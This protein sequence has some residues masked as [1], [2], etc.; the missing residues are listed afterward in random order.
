[1]IG[2][3]FLGFTGINEAVHTKNKCKKIRFLGI[4]LVML[5]AIGTMLALYIFQ[6]NQLLPVLKEVG[7][8]TELLTM[9]IIGTFLFGLMGAWL[10][11]TNI[12]FL[13]SDLPLWLSLPI[14]RKKLVTGKT[15]IAYAFEL[16]PAL[17]F[18]LPPLI[19]VGIAIQASWSFYVIGGLGIIFLPIPAFILG[20]L[21]GILTQTLFKGLLG[22]KTM[23]Q[24]IL[25]IAFTLGLIVFTLIAET[26]Q[27]EGIWQ[28]MISYLSLSGWISFMTSHFKNLLL[29]PSFIRIILYFGIHMALLELFILVISQQYE[30]ILNLFKPKKSEFTAKKITYKNSSVFLSLYQREFKRYFSTSIYVLN[31]IFSEVLLLV[32]TIILMVQKDLA[33]MI[34]DSIGAEFGIL[35]MPMAMMGIFISGMMVLSCTTAASISLEGKKFPMLKSLPVPTMTIFYAKLAVNLT[36]CFVALGICLPFIFWFLPFTPF[37]MLLTIWLT[38]GYSVF[39]ALFGLVINLKFP[40]FDWQNE[41]TVVKQS[42]STFLSI[43]GGMIAVGGPIFIGLRFLEI[44]MQTLLVGI[45][46]FITLVNISLYLGLKLK[47]V[48]WFNNLELK[49]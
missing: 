36:L 19:M 22:K 34:I 29:E 21:L 44:E 24:T 46:I 35:E 38:V 10:K 42:V 16:L 48:R 45:A 7:M 31:T 15:I 41:V 37:E 4:S 20:T 49:S 27:W 6:L 47:G 3:Y 13:S 23:I 33:L 8:E 18:M 40:V 1:M 11:S 30:N 26:F 2:Q 25:W 9:G 43:F 39:T 32:F 5:Y 14:S 28:T 17:G 12:L